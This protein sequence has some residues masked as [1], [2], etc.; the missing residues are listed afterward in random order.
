MT[1]ASKHGRVHS[2]KMLQ[3][4]L[5]ASPYAWAANGLDTK[6]IYK[7]V[8]TIAA[9]VGFREVKVEEPISD[10]LS[11]LRDFIIDTKPKQGEHDGVRLRV[12]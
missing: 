2:V 7:A 5:N 10:S 4:W 3:I 9:R 6:P 1:Y 12:L 8:C 11:E